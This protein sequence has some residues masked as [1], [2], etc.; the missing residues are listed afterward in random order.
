MFEKEI[1]AFR[2]QKL[3]RSLVCVEGEQDTTLTIQGRRFLSLA[4]N[5]YLGLANHPKLKERSIQAIKNYGV[6]SGASRFISGNSILYEKLEKALSSFKKVPTCLVFNSGFTANISIIPTLNPSNGMILADELNHASLFE[7]CRLSPSMV[8]VYHHKD[9]HHLEKLISKYSKEKPILIVTDGVFSMDGDLA[10][11][12][13]IHK[14]SEKYGARILVDDAHGTGVLGSHGRGIV[15]HFNLEGKIDYQVG[16]LGKSLGTFGAFIACD[17]E[18]RTYL[19]QKAKALIYTTALPPVILAATIEA[20]KLLQN[21][22]EFRE[23]LWKNRDYYVKELTSMGFNTLQSETP[24]VPILIGPSDLALRFS[25]KLFEQG[26]FAP[27]IRPP[28][29]PKG[30]SRIRTTVMSTHTLEQLD[31]ALQSLYTIGKDL[32]LLNK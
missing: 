10:P 28:T 9:M 18:T 4:S 14:L 12:P 11:L 27:A 5:N 6:G 30:S 23:N 16:T 19:M 31:F 3:L 24:I 1:S 17:F 15:E 2:D 8:R 26:I 21:H 7:G 32:G 25:K 22:P 29:V 13:K 20:L